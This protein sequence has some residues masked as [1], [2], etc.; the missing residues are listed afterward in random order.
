MEHWINYLTITILA[1]GL[2]ALLLADNRKALAVA[3]AAV[4]LMIFVINI[5]FWS[6]GFSL[7]KLL[8]SIMAMVILMLT[9]EHGNFENHKLPGTGKIFSAVGLAFAIILTIFTIG[10][11][12]SFLAIAPDQVLPSFFVLFC[13][14]IMLGI[15]QQP[16]RIILGLLILLAGFE[17]LYGSVEKSLLINGLLMAVTLL[18]AMVGS[19]LLTPVEKEAEE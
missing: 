10:R 2:F 15:S 1:A 7:S 17:I 12:S 9:N 18:I 6:F 16:F 11:T 13:G 5:Q 8:T 4:V 3:Y 19:Y 14:F